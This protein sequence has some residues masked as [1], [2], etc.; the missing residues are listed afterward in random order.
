[1][2]VRLEQVAS[3][4]VSEHFRLEAEFVPPVDY[5]LLSFDCWSHFRL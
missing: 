4:Q 1:M 3:A 5:C 2:V